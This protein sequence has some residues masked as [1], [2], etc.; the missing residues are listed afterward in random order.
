M[1][2]IRY[3]PVSIAV[4]SS[5]PQSQGDS[6]VYCCRYR[7]YDC[8]GDR[9]PEPV[10]PENASVTNLSGRRSDDSFSSGCAWYFRDLPRRVYRITP[11]DLTIGWS[12]VPAASLR[13]GRIE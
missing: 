12:N 13:A 10:R 8:I 11:W 7:D 4:T 6:S 5:E 1:D 2:S 9:I 3:L